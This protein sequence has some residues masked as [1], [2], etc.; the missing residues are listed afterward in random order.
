MSNRKLTG[1]SVDK[2]QTDCE[3]DVDAALNDDLEIVRI[4]VGAHHFAENDQQREES[5]NGTQTQRPPDCRRSDRLFIGW[6]WCCL[7]LNLFRHVLAE[8]SCRTH[9]QYH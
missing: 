2:I 5:N 3:D 1:N 9:E 7:H 4:E 8:Q 6:L